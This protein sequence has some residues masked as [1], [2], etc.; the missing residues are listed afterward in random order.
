[1]L[2]ILPS[3][4]KLPHEQLSHS[5]E[6]AQAAQCVQAGG[7]IA[8]PTESVYGLG[9]DPQNEKAIQRLLDIKQRRANKGLIIVA[10]FFRQLTLYCKPIPKQRER[11]VRATWPGPHT[12]LFPAKE[13]CSVLLTGSHSTI[14]VR[15]SAHPT[16]RSLCRL[17][18]HALVST[19]ANHSQQEPARSSTEVL[20][21]FGNNVDYIISGRIEGNKKPTPITDA[22][23]GQVVR[24]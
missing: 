23:S 18:G 10:S 11:I 14:A 7:I 4:T 3:L 24:A 5:K 21:E 9:C 22:L 13:T 20:V 12:W 1:M 8:Y 16:V 6:L 19:S 2:R 17:C 15:L